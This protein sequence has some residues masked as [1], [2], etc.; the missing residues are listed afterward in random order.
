MIRWVLALAA[1]LWAAAAARDGVDHWVDATVLPSLALTTSVEVVDRNGDLLRAYTMA[2]GR[3]RLPVSLHA[4]DPTYLAL[5]IRYEDKRFYDHGGVDPLAMLRAMGQALRSGRVVSGGSTLTMQVARLLENGGT[6]EIA[7][8]LRQI[9]V[10]LAL[11]RQISKDDILTLY[12]N[13]A[14][15]GGN[16]EGVRAASYAYFDR[17]P[18]LLTT[19]QAALLVA[20]PQSPETR[21]PDRAATAA[22]ETRNAVLTRLLENGAINSERYR[23]ATR[24]PV[25]S[26]RHS[27]PALAPHFA[28][29]AVAA[30]PQNTR[31]QLTLDRTVQAA[32][33]RLAAD[34]V[35]QRSDRVQVAI[36]VAD[37]Q[38]GE[39]IASVGSAA[40][41][42]D[43]R[44][45]FMDLTQAVRSPGSTLKPLIY[46][47]GFDQGLIHPETLIADRPTD[48]DGYQPQNFDGMFRGELRVR[49][50]LQQS[51]NIPAVAVTQALG[52]HHLVAGMRRAGMDPQI[53]G[54]APGLAV[55]LGGVGVTLTELVQ[56]YGAI[57]NDGR[58][59]DLRGYAQAT[60]GFQ[61]QVV[62]N[63][64]AAW[65]VA[66]ILLETPRPRGV[67][68]TGIAYKTGTSYGHRDAWAVGFDGQHVVGV[69]MG[70]ADG[71]PV[72]GAFGGDL[73]A[74][75]MFAA[76]ARVKPAVTP[77][78]AP[79][80]ATLLVTN[81]QLPQHLRQ[82]GQ[83]QQNT[84]PGPSIA[85]P[86]DGAILQGSDLTLKVRD[87][88]PPY[89][90]L[91]N[92]A[93]IAQSYRSQV[94]LSDIGQGFAAITV[95]DATGQSEQAQIEI[96][97][98]AAR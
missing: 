7:G 47:L 79:P 86:P 80:R 67:Q 18:R 19:A 84:V 44:A 15:F 4:V 97:P 14:P 53:P 6:G 63:P 13:H 50:A 92:G 11:E 65:Q 3:W 5:L 28:D 23:S 22:T 85:F 37:H 26:T 24:D 73:A 32:L 48:F 51:L 59:V 71:T 81:A 12:L 83:Q 40:Y 78:K 1:G 62:M 16:I 68:A 39:I 58:A 42:A 46:G 76:F 88:L 60:P 72:P 20:L 29:R 64:V 91:L 75:V 45:G 74:P 36:V 52:P 21:R 17:A 25:S 8:K 98:D 38:T 49:S 54:G 82:F 34:A 61:P 56:L 9:R 96:Q 87:G 10:A 69:W 66:D 43:G 27:F 93:P 95:I 77:I 70:R 35:A 89:V 55:A 94:D 2:D 31:H 30:N 57:G 33:E 90:W 41:Q